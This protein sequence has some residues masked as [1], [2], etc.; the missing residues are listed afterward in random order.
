MENSEENQEVQETLIKA[1]LRKG[2]FTLVEGVY[3]SVF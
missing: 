2:Y 3:D 1:G